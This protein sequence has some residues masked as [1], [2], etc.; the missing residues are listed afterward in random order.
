[1]RSSDSDGTIDI[2][3]FPGSFD[4]VQRESRQLRDDSSPGCFQSPEDEPPAF[5]ALL[6][7][8]VYK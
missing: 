4:Q 8:Q 6:S 3:G 2:H 5:G 1:M 7:S